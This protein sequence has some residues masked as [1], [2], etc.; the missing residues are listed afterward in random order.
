MTITSAIIPFSSASSGGGGSIDSITGP[1]II[2]DEGP[3]GGIMDL[4]P[5]TSG[6]TFTYNV[7]ANSGSAGGGGAQLALVRSP[8][9]VWQ[10]GSDIVLYAGIAGSA[11]SLTGGYRKEG[12]NTN[13]GFTLFATGPSTP[14]TQNMEEVI[15]WSGI[16]TGWSARFTDVTGP[17]LSVNFD[18]VTTDMTTAGYASGKELDDTSAT[19]QLVSAGQSGSPWIQPKLSISANAIDAP[20]TETSDESETFRISLEKSGETTLTADF[21]FDFS[22]LAQN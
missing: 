21:I 18:Y 17:P 19:T 4:V 3:A 8:L 16:G 14:A 15:R 6:N 1:S 9:V 13:Y 2:Y 11:T 7:N 22:V 20:T 12:D 10:D 5:L